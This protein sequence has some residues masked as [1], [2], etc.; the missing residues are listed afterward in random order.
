MYTD[1]DGVLRVR[2]WLSG[3]ADDI[4]LGVSGGSW[5]KLVRLANV[6]AG[7]VVRSIERLGLEVAPQKTQATFFFDRRASGSPPEGL[8]LR[9]N[10]VK[11]QITLHMRYLGMWLDGPRSFGEHVA[12]VAPRAVKMANNLARFL[13]NIGGAS[14]GVRRLYV[15]TFH[16]V[17]LY[18]A[19]IWWER[20]AR[21]VTLSARMAAAQR[22]IANRAARAY[23]TVSHV[24]ATILAGIPPVTL[25]AESY[26]KTYDDV[27]AIKARLGVVRV[28]ERI[29]GKL[30]LQN[31]EI[32]LQKWKTF[33][34]NPNL[35]GR[36]IR[37]AVQPVLEGW[38]ERKK[39]RY[40]TF[41]AS[42][43][44]RIAMESSHLITG[45][46]VI[47]LSFFDQPWI[48]SYA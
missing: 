42:Q 48:Y 38:M 32:L 21:S 15:A 30:R 7:C 12:R 36:R 35:M 34:E 28:P 18:A 6:A 33:L 10:G 23:R 40:L 24:G 17:L 29:R 5:Q 31:A 37:E 20:L 9:I 3:Y 25:I 44:P 27:K 19:P 26:A 39:S 45:V 46:G 4:Y 2:C 11:V 13:P 22:I 16:S 43:V 41:H 14:G 8:S 1:Q 47:K